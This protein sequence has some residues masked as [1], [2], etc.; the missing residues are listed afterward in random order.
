MVQLEVAD[1]LAA[2][3][4]SKVYGVPSVKAAWYA[5]VRRAGV[6]GRN[7]VLAGAQRRLR[8]GGDASAGAAAP[9]PSGGSGSSR[10]SMPPSR[11]GARCC[12][13][14]WPGIAGAGAAAAARAGRAAGVDPTARGERLTVEDFARVA[15]VLPAPGLSRRTDFGRPAAQAAQ[16]ARSLERVTAVT[17]RTPGQDQPGAGCRCAAGRRLPPGRH[18]LP[19]DLAVR[20]GPGA[21][22]LTT[23]RSP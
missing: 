5:D 22:R 11:S 13:R 9:V 21:S 4:G 2:R 10:S 14:R 19:G 23:A 20:R 1:R 8:S 7:R 3:P 16:S 18:G 15:D 17:V 6:V 12:G